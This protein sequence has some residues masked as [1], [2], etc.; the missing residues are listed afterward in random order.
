MNATMTNRRYENTLFAVIS[1][2]VGASIHFYYT[3]SLPDF[4]IAGN[5]VWITLKCGILT[6][7]LWGITLFL[8]RFIGKQITDTPKRLLIKMAVVIVFGLVVW[9]YCHYICAIEA[10]RDWKD[11]IN[12]NVG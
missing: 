11:M 3:T 5:D 9:G 6:F 7:I 4:D 8:F 2:I 10:V 12:G 1:L